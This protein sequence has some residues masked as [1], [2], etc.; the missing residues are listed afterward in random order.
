[1]DKSLK[2]LGDVSLTWSCFQGQDLIQTVGGCV[3]IFHFL[4]QWR[5]RIHDWNFELF[6][7]VSSFFFWTGS[8]SPQSGGEKKIVETQQS[9]FGKVFNLLRQEFSQDFQYLWLYCQVVSTE[10]YRVYLNIWGRGSLA[11]ASSV[12]A[13]NLGEVNISQS[14]YFV[15]CIH[16]ALMICTT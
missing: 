16:L 2:A 5:Y 11:A 4:L 8:S 13:K 12:S 9:S 10:K 14:R 15:T 3:R 7:S 1:M 6:P